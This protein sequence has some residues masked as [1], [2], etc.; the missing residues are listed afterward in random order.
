MCISQLDQ[1]VLASII[2]SGTPSSIPARSAVIHLILPESD[3]EFFKLN[4]M[5][6]LGVRI[7]ASA[8]DKLPVTKIRFGSPLEP[9]AFS[10]LPSIFPVSPVRQLDSAHPLG[11]KLGTFFQSSYYFIPIRFLLGRGD[12]QAVFGN[13]DST[14][15]LAKMPFERAGSLKFL[16]NEIDP[17]S[18][19]LKENDSQVP[20]FHTVVKLLR[21]NYCL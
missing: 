6:I 17:K 13:Q 8:R 18:P 7:F 16:G 2:G 4:K 14:I 1:V 3:V 12:L 9:G 20:D 5:A 21:Q 11:P 10:V 15:P 19:A